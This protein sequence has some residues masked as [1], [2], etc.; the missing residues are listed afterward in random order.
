MPKLFE[1]TYEEI[2]D[3]NEKCKKVLNFKNTA[4][5]E[6]SDE[7]IGQERAQSAMEFG[8]TIREKGYNIYIS[9][10]SGS[11]RTYYAKKM[12]EKAAE[13]SSVPDDW[14][15]VYNFWNKLE[16][17]ALSFKAGLGKIFKQN[18]EYFINEIITRIPQIFSSEEYDRQKN[19][20]MEDYHNIKTSLIYELNSIAEAYDLQLKA[21][22]SGFAFIPTADGKPMNENEFDSMDALDREAILKNVAEV[23][24]KAIDIL[25]KLKNAEKEAD[26]RIKILDKKIG[27][28][29]IE[30]LIQDIKSK[31]S[32]NPDVVEYIEQVKDD[33]LENLY[34]FING[35]DR[36]PEIKDEEEFLMRYRVNLVVDNSDKKGAPVIYET[37]PTY[38]NLMGT[39]EY[40]SKQG[41]MVTDF[42]MIRSGSIMKANGGYLIIMADDLLKNYQAWQG[43]KRV[44]KS[45]EIRPEGIRSQLDLIAIT[46]LKPKPVHVDV[47]V[48][49]IGNEYI[50]RLLHEMDDDFNEL[51]KVKVDF[52]PDMEKTEANIYKVARFI[53]N[54][55]SKNGIRH[56]DRSAVSAVI[57]LGSRMA[58]GGKRMSA[59]L[60]DLTDMVK[61]SNIWAGMA[62][63]NYITGE[64]I[65]KAAFERKKRVNS[66][67]ERMLRQYRDKKIMINVTGEAVGQVN[68]LSV[69]DLGGYSF[70]KPYRITATT[71][72]GKSGIINV[73]RE[74]HMS[75]NVYNKSVMIIAGYLGGQ[76]ARDIPLSITAHVCFEQL[77]GYIDGD[78]ASIAELYAILSSLS[79]VPI[80]Q[81]IA[82]TGSMNQMGE[83]QPVGGINEK[84][85]GFYNV[86]SFSGLDGSHGVII[87]YCNIDD[88]MLE[89]DVMRAIKKGL[90]H[91]YAIKNV[92]QGI[93]IL[94]GRKLGKKDK[95]GQ[96]E[97]D[98]LNY[99]VDIR[100]RES[101]R[102]YGEN[103][104]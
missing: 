83:V 84:I 2:I 91:I 36:H 63:R 1:V 58:G 30:R 79:G 59:R 41:I 87:P 70:G 34:I 57:E 94:T 104:T 10:D 76:Y 24:T 9:G 21:T 3:A 86:C 72:M 75:G 18:M 69:V 50:Y 99:Y 8:I 44:L 26:D 28:Y 64:D 92:E 19:E 52:D 60:E 74:A 97:K 49:L 53:S 27:L 88:L 98:T 40:E 15:Y 56:L 73:E 66:I 4:E 46:A 42:L 65:K 71:Y 20:I 14:C 16:P 25:R 103:K 31:Y 13:Q 11:G 61:E 39:V 80:K 48:V 101:L 89:D 6:G 22:G 33:I 62:G 51:F 43:L 55:C 45:R 38:N 68:G 77:Y 96:F 85:E 32:Y 81:C 90:F 37:N 7:L 102:N 82:V 54:Y 47:K 12:L 23:R 67:E 78:S 95:N 29:E 17:V 35:I 100:L 93:E 5:I